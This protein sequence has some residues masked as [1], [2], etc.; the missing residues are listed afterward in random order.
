MARG[1]DDAQVTADNIAAV[2]IKVLA[3][4]ADGTDTLDQ[5]QL[6]V[7]AAADAFTSALEAIEQAAINDN[8]NPNPTNPVGK[9]NVSHYSDLGITTVTGTNLGSHQPAFGRYYYRWA[10][11][12]LYRDRSHGHKLFIDPVCGRE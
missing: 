8:A 12:Q 2:N 1:V 3:A 7:N 9:I 10:G 11:R 4:N 5:I 6:L